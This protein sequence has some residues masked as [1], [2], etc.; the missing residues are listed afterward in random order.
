LRKAAKAAGVKLSTVTP[1]VG[2]INTTKNPAVAAAA[3]DLSGRVV[4]GYEFLAQEYRAGDKIRLF[5][6]MAI[7][8]L[9]P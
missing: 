1:V 7:R 8:P 9:F 2:T 6:V 3:G 4:G 5:G